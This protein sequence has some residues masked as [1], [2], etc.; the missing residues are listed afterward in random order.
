MK[1]NNTLL[2][3]KAKKEPIPSDTP[4]LPKRSESDELVLL[5]KLM[6]LVVA[7][8]ALMRVIASFER[9]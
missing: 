7:I 5:L 2:Q 9:G 8:V 6:G 4:N 1:Q 3:D